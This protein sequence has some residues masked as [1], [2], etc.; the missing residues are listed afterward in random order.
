VAEPPSRRERRRLE[1]HGRILEAALALF[2]S[3]GYEATTVGEI[4]DRADIAY[5]TFFKHFPAKLDLL[6][7]LADGQ[8]RDLFRDL[9]EIRKTSSSFSERLVLLFE[10]AARRA[11]ENGP[12]ARELLGAMMTLAYPETAAKD[13]LRMRLAFQQLL[14]DGFGS[15]AIRDDVD[16]DTLVEVVIGAWYSMFLSWVHFEGYPL[17]ERATAVAHFLARTLTTPWED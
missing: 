4:A 3:Q 16:R 10:G 7:E 12:Q 11:E 13:D 14:D 9:E 6:R 5:G 17:R 8:L 1:I 15:G 2:E